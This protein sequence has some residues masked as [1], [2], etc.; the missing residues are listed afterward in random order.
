VLADAAELGQRLRERA[1]RTTGAPGEELVELARP[2]DRGDR[3]LAAHD[4]LRLP[5]GAPHRGG[6]GFPRPG[7]G[8]SPA[9]GLSPRRSGGTRTGRCRAR[10][11]D[12]SRGSGG[13]VEPGLAGLGDV[14]EDGPR[15][16]VLAGLDEEALGGGG[17]DAG[18]AT[19]A[20]GGEVATA[21]GKD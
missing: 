11:A 13:L 19:E 7:E 12:G 17:P 9:P 14:G 4:E 2:D 21:G 20:G 8:P 16:E 5:R 6:G 18:G 3:L 1:R 10:A 15:A